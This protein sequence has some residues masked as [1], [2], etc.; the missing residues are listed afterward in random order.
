[1]RR[2]QGFQA[3]WAGGL[4]LVARIANSFLTRRPG[5]G[6]ERGFTLVELSIVLVIVGLIIAGVL[7]GQELLENTRMKATLA[8]VEGIR[9]AATLFAERYQA[10]PGDYPDS[11][12][13]A[14]I[15]GVDW[16]NSCDED[17][18]KPKDK[19]CDGDST[20]EG[21]GITGETVLFWQHLAASKFIRGIEIDPDPFT[22]G[23]VV[24]GV[25]LPSNPVG[26]G[27][28]VFNEAMNGVL[29]HWL[30]LGTGEADP[31]GVLNADTG[32]IIDKK[33]DDGRP[34]TGTVQTVDTECITA[35]G[36][37]GVY[38]LVATDPTAVACLMNFDLGG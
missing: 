15:V 5:H 27:L 28:T 26:G 38:Q 3:A 20:I 36:P 9:S 1:V 21:D 24:Y 18:K 37:T 31:D 7:K 19:K 17:K 4:S 23:K 8:Q 34:A 16:G 2:F 25:S 29:T 10:L 33:I 13:L 32:K 22:A 11:A 14:A 30:R 12:D 35:D 6:A